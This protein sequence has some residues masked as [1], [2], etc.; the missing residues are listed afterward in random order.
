MGLR[1]SVVIDDVAGDGAAAGAAARL[2]CG[3]DTR[4]ARAAS[5]AVSTHVHERSGFTDICAR[6]C[7]LAIGANACL[8]QRTA[9]HAQA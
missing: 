7:T 1:F 6:M 2:T 8:A 3:N 4:P 9:T 5:P